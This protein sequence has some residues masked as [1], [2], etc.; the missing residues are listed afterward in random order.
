MSDEHS[1]D[2]DI[3]LREHFPWVGLA[4]FDE[5]LASRY[6]EIMAGSHRDPRDRRSEAARRSA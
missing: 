5:D 1:T 2:L 3:A 4:S 6:R